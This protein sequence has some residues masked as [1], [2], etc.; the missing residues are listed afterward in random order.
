MLYI[1]WEHQKNETEN[2]IKI[3]YKI[4]D[5]DGNLITQ[6]ESLPIDFNS[7]RNDLKNNIKSLIDVSYADEIRLTNLE[8]PFYT[9]MWKKSFV[10]KFWRDNNFRYDIIVNI[11]SE[12]NIK[13]NSD[14]NTTKLP[15]NSDKLSA[16]MTRIDTNKHFEHSWNICSKF[17]S[18]PELES[19]LEE[20]NQQDHQF[21]LSQPTENQKFPVEISDLPEEGEEK[22][23][24]RYLSLNWQSTSGDDRLFPELK[25]E[26][27][28]SVEPKGKPMLLP[29]ISDGD[30][31]GYKIKQN[32][33]SLVSEINDGD[34]VCSIKSN[35][36]DIKSAKSYIEAFNKTIF[37]LVVKIV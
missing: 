21:I 33:S 20:F 8:V 17:S 29:D 2:F 5:T 31:I 30:V 36:K 10:V 13:Q 24:K 35:F 25:C 7:D 27:L 15:D 1:I 14:I 34:L 16:E 9:N 26:L 6:E 11:K 32:Y 19:Y 3:K 22:F 18:L 23:T 28:M 37:Q 4:K 12:L